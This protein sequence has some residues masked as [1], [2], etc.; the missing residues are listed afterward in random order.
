MHKNDVPEQYKPMTERLIIALLDIAQQLYSMTSEVGG[1][2]F[3][4]GNGDI[5]VSITACGKEPVDA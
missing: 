3:N 4:A 5:K 1:V 2:G